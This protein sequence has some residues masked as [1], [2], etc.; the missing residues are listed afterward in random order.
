M[1]PKYLFSPLFTLFS[2]SP[3]T[4]AQAQTEPAKPAEDAAPASPEAAPKVEKK[5]SI[6]ETKFNLRAQVDLWTKD[7]NNKSA[8]KQPRLEKI[9]TKLERKQ[10]DV[11]AFV[12][13][14]LTELE[15]LKADKTDVKGTN[16]APTPVVK[17]VALNAFI[18]RYEITYKTPLGLKI[19][20]GRNDAP[21]LQGYADPAGADITAKGASTSFTGYGNTIEGFRFNYDLEDLGLK[22][23]YWVARDY[24]VQSQLSLWN[25]NPTAIPD[26]AA[27]EPRTWYH[28]L[29]AS[30]KMGVATVNL[31]LGA[32]TQ[33]LRGLGDAADKTESKLNT[34]AFLQ[35]EMAV[36][37]DVKVKAGVQMDSKTVR[38]VSTKK[39]GQTKVTTAMVGVK[40][41]L[42]PKMLNLMADLSFRT[43][44]WPDKLQDDYS[45]TEKDLKDK[46]SDMGITAAAGISLDESLMLV[47]SV[48][49]FSNSMALANVTRSDDKLYDVRSGMKNKDGKAAKTQTVM[50]IAL[51]LNY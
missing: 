28:H 6:N 41:D 40:A 35:G 47:P 29:L 42:V 32:Q 16:D 31:G 44:K 12:E 4:V 1:K 30:H 39:L 14:T 17:D 20:W 27:N 24:K 19:T 8:A 15:R 22:L 46:T 3:W 50:G 45:T 9:R 43:V 51:R 11:N 36:S 23:Q 18:R 13:L 21:N 5:V 2:I 49:Y 38:V 34:N 10:G 26:S 37:E 7:L 33:I 25:N 48:G